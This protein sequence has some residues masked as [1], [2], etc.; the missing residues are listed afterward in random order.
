MEHPELTT[1]QIAARVGCSPSNLSQ[2]PPFQR[3]R[4]QIRR[5]GSVR[6]AKRS[7]NARTGDHEVYILNDNDESS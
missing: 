5:S 1:T 2:Y 7:K 3:L 4:E 6:I